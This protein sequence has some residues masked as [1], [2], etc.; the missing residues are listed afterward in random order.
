MMRKLEDI[1]DAHQRNYRVLI[2]RQEVPCCSLFDGYVPHC[3][4]LGIPEDRIIIKT[5]TGL[6]HDSVRY[7]PKC[8]KQQ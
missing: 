2:G 6:C 1:C 4:Y 5:Q 8:H 3:K 7:Y